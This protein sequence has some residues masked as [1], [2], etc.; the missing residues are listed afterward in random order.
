MNISANSYSS[1]ILDM[2]SSHL[3]S[4]P[5]SEYIGQEEISIRRLDSIF[6][7]VCNHDDKLYIKIDTQGYEKCVLEG[8]E[9]A[10]ESVD[11]LELELSFIPLY[12][13]GPLFHEMFNLLYKKGFVLVHVEPG[14]T[15]P[16]TGQILQVD[17]IFQRIQR[18]Q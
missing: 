13:D 8:A 9:K 6:N 11:I 12:K 7:D 5:E 14:F 16:S 15:D 3:E 1:S 18:K 10:L 2:L 4:A 17:G